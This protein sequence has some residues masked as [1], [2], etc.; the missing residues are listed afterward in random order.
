MQR[1]ARVCL[2]VFL[3]ACVWVWGAMWKLRIYTHVAHK[4]ESFI[5]RTDTHICVYCSSLLHVR[6]SLSLKY[7]FVS[8]ISIFILLFSRLAQ[9]RWYWWKSIVPSIERES[10]VHYI[11]IFPFAS[12]FPPIFSSPF[13]THTNALYVRACIISPICSNQ[14]DFCDVSKGNWTN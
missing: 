5:S 8:L 2:L 10:N 14:T 3:Y 4:T 6:R 11:Y 1:L 12:L 7:G 13:A 9:C